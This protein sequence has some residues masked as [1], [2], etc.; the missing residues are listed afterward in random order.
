MTLNF[1]SLIHSAS[2]KTKVLAI[3]DIVTDNSS[4]QNNL[5]SQ[6][7]DPDF[8]VSDIYCDLSNSS[9]R[10]TLVETMSQVVNNDGFDGVS[11]DIEPLASGTTWLPQMIQQFKALTDGKTVIVY[12]FSLVNDSKADGYN[13]STSYLKSVCSVADYVELRLYNFNA[14]TIDAY[15]ADVLDQIAR[16][17]SANLTAKI[18]FVLPVFPASPIHDPSIETIANAGSLVQTFNTGLFSQTYMTQNDYTQY[19]ALSQQPAS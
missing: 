3:V 16:V 17:E 11:L 12:G 9:N 18:L 10:N 6:N 14:T 7:K 15:Q 19:L 5:I 2:S 8:T 4:S 1:A 13:W